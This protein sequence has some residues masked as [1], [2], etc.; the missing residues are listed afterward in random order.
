MNY[1]ATSVPDAYAAA[2]ALPVE[3]MAAELDA[4]A[5]MVEPPAGPLILDVGC[6]TGRFSAAMAK[7]FGARVIGVEPSA[8]MLAQTEQTERPYVAFVQG[9]AS[10]LPV[11][12]GACDLIFLSNVW[13]HIPA[14]ETAAAEFARALAPRGAVVVRNYVA[15][16]LAA[17]G[18]L[19]FFPE[20]RAVSERDTPSTDDVAA[21]MAS[22][23]FKP[24]GAETLIQ[25]AAPSPEA[26]V[27]KVAARVYSDLA[28]IPDDAFARGL[29]AMRAALAA[30]DPIATDEPL[31]LLAFRRAG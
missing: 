13:H 31:R 28:M 6:G 27:E 24:A 12:D 11:G 3:V 30:G 5:R 19:K 8:R 22:A 10:R 18:Y 7:R 20:A 15:E 1:D 2:R 25:P 16:D 17:L 26:Y 29:D 23:G 14:P 21:A 4:V 9:E